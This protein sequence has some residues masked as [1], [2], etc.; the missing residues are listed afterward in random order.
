MLGRKIY[1]SSSSRRDLVSGPGVRQRA[2]VTFDVTSFKFSAAS[3]CTSHPASRIIVVVADNRSCS[4]PPSSGPH[5]PSLSCALP[6]L[7]LISQLS[8]HFVLHMSSH[9]PA[10]AAS[11]ME[12][13]DAAPSSVAT[14]HHNAL[15]LSGS[16]PSIHQVCLLIYLVVYLILIWC[17]LARCRHTCSHVSSAD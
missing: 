11:P 4:Q 14:N 6:G 16:V 5:L 3:R 12:I 17:G 15:G 7:L 8:H 13:D 10:H 9:K 1:D 2:A